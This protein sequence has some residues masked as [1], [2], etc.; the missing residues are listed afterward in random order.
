MVRLEKGSSACWIF[1][2]LFFFF[3]LFSPLCVV[4]LAGGLAV[5]MCVCVCVSM[6]AC[7]EPG[8]TGLVRATKALSWC[9]PKI[10][11][12]PLQPFLEEAA[13]RVPVLCPSPQ[14]HTA[15]TALL[16]GCRQR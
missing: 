1:L 10:P 15:G 7:V 11:S 13:G 8:V 6:Q 4:G 9:E 16:Q 12:P 5:V 14:H 3:M 2:F